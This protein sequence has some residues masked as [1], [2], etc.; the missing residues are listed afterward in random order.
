MTLNPIPSC[1]THGLEIALVA[2]NDIDERMDGELADQEHD[3]IRG[4]DFTALLY[5]E[6]SHLLGG[7][8]VPIG[9]SAAPTPWPVKEF[10]ETRRSASPNALRWSLHGPAPSEC[11]RFSLSF[12]DCDCFR[13]CDLRCLEQRMLIN[14]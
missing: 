7:M 4:V 12:S 10:K 14:E 2:H 1:I 11:F 8:P 6:P 3:P 5:E 13:D 9:L